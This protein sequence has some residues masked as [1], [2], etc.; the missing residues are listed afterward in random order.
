VDAIITDPV[1]QRWPFRRQAEPARQGKE[2]VPRPETRWFVGDKMGTATRAEQKLHGDQ[3]YEAAR[4]HAGLPKDA[5][6][7]QG[8]GAWGTKN[9][10]LYVETFVPP[11]SVSV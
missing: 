5:T 4:K 7:H 10:P 2:C 9:N 1:L 3:L 6:S 11:G 8:C